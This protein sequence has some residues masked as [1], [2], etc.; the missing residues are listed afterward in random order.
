VHVYCSDVACSAAGTSVA[1]RAGSP[2]IS[3]GKEKVR[4]TEAYGADVHSTPA[5]AIRDIHTALLTFECTF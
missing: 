4:R 2:S 5:A 3:S 1:K